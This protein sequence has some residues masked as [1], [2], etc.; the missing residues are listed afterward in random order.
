MSLDHSDEIGWL[1][2]K[3]RKVNTS[4]I[5]KNYGRKIFIE[6]FYDSGTMF[7]VLQPKKSIT[8][9]LRRDHDPNLLKNEIQGPKIFKQL[10]HSWK[11][12]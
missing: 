9:S 11:M 5:V 1:E 2:L 3:I 4:V 12:I 7:V 8:V 6:T 10:L